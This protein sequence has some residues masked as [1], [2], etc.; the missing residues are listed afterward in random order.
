MAYDLAATDC[1]GPTAPLVVK[2]GRVV[3]EPV[4][5]L[6]TPT[7]IRDAFGYYRGGENGLWGILE[8]AREK[9][10][11]FEPHELT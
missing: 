1:C 7:L 8:G 10:N 5:S 2:E 11:L 9:R 3:T 6:R 4:G